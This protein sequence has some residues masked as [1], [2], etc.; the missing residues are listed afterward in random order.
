MRVRKGLRE[1]GMRLAWWKKT[2]QNHMKRVTHG[3][4]RLTLKEWL[5]R[6][7]EFEHCCAYCGDELEGMGWIEHLQPLSRGGVHRKE[8]VV[9]S[10]QS[11]NQRKGD[12][13]LEEFQAKELAQLE[14]DKNNV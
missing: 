7:E 13:T 5:E 12:M 9:P 11:C 1:R 10:C 3:P 14:E 4:P 2:T 8:N 6:L